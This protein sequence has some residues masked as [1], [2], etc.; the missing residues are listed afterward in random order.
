M[1]LLL[2]APHT[3][4][5]GRFTQAHG[6]SRLTAAAFD[7]NQR[8]LLTAGND[9]SVRMWNFNNGSLLREYKHSERNIT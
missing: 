3:P 6:E 2:P 7:V 8:R 9:G 1:F 5:E 4:R